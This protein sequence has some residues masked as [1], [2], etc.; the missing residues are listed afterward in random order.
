MS[1]SRA[2]FTDAAGRQQARTDPEARTGSRWR[3]RLARAGVGP[4]IAGDRVFLR[5]PRLGDWR[6]WVALR[7]QSR[8]FLA[9]WEPVWS[10]DHLSKAAFRR[11]LHHYRHNETVRA[12]LIFRHEDDALLGGVTLSNIRFGVSKSC[13]LGYWIGAP[14]ARQGYMSEA[15]DL[16]LNHAFLSLGLHRIEAACL[17]ANEASRRLLDK[18]GFR[19]EGLAREYLKINGRWQDHLLFAL[20]KSDPRP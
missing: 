18:C 11:R 7:R 17:P 6:A 14:Y 16:V 8:D 9:P 5:P 15:L 12:F 4:V 1:G 19:Q 13:S 20:L 3:L 2:D 10:R